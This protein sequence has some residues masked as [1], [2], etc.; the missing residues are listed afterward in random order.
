M[1]KKNNKNPWN[2][3]EL[4]CLLEEK[5]PSFFCWKSLH[6]VASYFAQPAA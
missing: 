2:A 5:K 6:A 4:V 3:A 1:E